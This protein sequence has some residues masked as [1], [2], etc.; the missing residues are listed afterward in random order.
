MIYKK[1]IKEYGLRNIG[2]NTI[3]PTGTT[4]LSI[5]NNCSSGIEPSFSLSYT[6]N[7]RSG[8]DEDTLSQTVYDNGWLEYIKFIDPEMYKLAL[9]GKEIQIERPSFFT[10][11]MEVDA[12]ASIDIQAIFQ[13][14]I[15]HSISKTLNLPPGTTQEEYD[16]LFMYAYKKGLKGF[17]TF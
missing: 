8:N 6:R 4:A 17:T 9:K 7:Y 12:Y 5:G 3:A 13:E 16:E 10:T 2:L 1:Q 11:T 14:Y 15:D